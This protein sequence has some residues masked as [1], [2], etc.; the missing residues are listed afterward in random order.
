MFGETFEFDEELLAEDE[1]LQEKRK[2]TKEQKANLLKGRIDRDTKADKNK[3]GKVSDEER[4]KLLK[5]D[6]DFY[7]DE[8]GF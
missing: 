3:D 1:M 4:K 2:L 8:E 6:D 5:E 7:F